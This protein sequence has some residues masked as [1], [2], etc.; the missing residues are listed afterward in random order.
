LRT[1]NLALAAVVIL[2][3]S[4]SL[5]MGKGSGSLEL[6]YIGR[7]RK[8]SLS[9]RGK[10]RRGEREKFCKQLWCTLAKLKLYFFIDAW[11]YKRKYTLSSR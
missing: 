9:S 4:Q 10:G 7:E 2:T 11:N 1:A 6:V 8:N 5:Q 3:A